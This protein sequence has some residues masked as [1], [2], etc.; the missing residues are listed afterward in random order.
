MDQDFEAMAGEV[1]AVK[2]GEDLMRMVLKAQSH[3]DHIKDQLNTILVNDQPIQIGDDL[4]LEPG[5][6]RYKGFR[7]GIR[8]ALEFI[9]EFPLEISDS[10]DSDDEG[11][12]F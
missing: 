10:S 7:A 4:T 1:K 5:T 2:G 3:H 6:D 8:V 9:G 11:E 12:E